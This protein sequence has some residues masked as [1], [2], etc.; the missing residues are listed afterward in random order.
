MFVTREFCEK[1]FESVKGNCDWEI[2]YLDPNLL[3]IIGNPIIENFIE[4]FRFHKYPIVKQYYNPQNGLYELTIGKII[5]GAAARDIKHYFDNNK[6]SIKEKKICVEPKCDERLPTVTNIVSIL[7]R[8]IPESMVI[9]V[10]EDNQ[11]VFDGNFFILSNDYKKIDELDNDLI[12]ANYDD[13]LVIYSLT[14]RDVTYIAK[15]IADY[16][17]VVYDEQTCSVTIPTK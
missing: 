2:T 11:I 15:A 14:D 3:Y 17:G 4:V 10:T 7:S 8:Y 16:Y 5:A 1:L 12:L 6:L 13:N 9:K